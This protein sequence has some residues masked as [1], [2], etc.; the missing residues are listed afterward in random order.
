MMRM[1]RSVLPLLLTSQLA[2]SAPPKVPEKLE[3]KVGEDTTLTIEIP[4]NTEIGM[5]KGFDP[6]DCTFFGPVLNGNKR[7]YLVSPKRNGKFYV[8]W[9]TKGE[10][11]HTQT[12]ITTNGGG[13]NDDGVVPPPTPTD[14]FYKELLAA[15]VADPSPTKVMDC[16]SL[17]AVYKALITPGQGVWAATNEQQL[18]DVLINSRAAVISERL[19][20]IRTVVANQYASA[21]T[22]NPA[23]PIT[24]AQKQ[25][26]ADTLAKA[27]PMLEVAK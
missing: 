11:D 8:T 12:I 22:G 5:A 2:W 25:K 20:G 27:I 4:A 6:K 19:E 21:F 15:F 9:W 17:A 23:A 1:M 13:G 26:V 16:K 14:P 18:W 10:I 24:Q 7:E 3:V